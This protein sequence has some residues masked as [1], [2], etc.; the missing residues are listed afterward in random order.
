MPLDFDRDEVLKLWAEIEAVQRS[1]DGKIPPKVVRL[2]GKARGVLLRDAATDASRAPP[3]VRL[4]CPDCGGECRL[5]R[6]EPAVPSV[7]LG[8]PH[9]YC[10]A[11]D[12]VGWGGVDTL[13]ARLGAHP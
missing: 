8:N 2:T 11:C 6:D 12:W 1:L 10:P 13:A 3:Y 7:H 4:L 5:I 9:P